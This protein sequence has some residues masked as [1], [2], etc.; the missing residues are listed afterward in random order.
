[1]TDA[2]FIG[3]IV[4]SNGKTIKENNF[5]L[6]HEYPIMSQ[7]KV[8]YCDSWLS[9][10]SEV[11]Q[12]AVKTGLP[13]YVVQHIRDC[14]GTP[15]YAVS[16]VPLTAAEDERL[17]EKY[18]SMVSNDRSIRKDLNSFIQLTDLVKTFTLFG[19]HSD[20]LEMV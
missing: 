20:D 6:K 3:D 7:V 19:I 8:V 18:L 12:N 9:R 4:E 14:D 13:F 10:E 15:L 11:I 16:F 17:N 2:V 5:S 1:M